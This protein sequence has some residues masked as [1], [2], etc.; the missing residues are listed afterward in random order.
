MQQGTVGDGSGPVVVDG[1]HVLAGEVMAQLRRCGVGVR[2]GAHAG[3]AAELELDAGGAAPSALVLVTAGRPP[4]AASAPWQRHGIPHL[5]VSVGIRDI[6]VG[7]LVVPGRTP[8]LVCAGAVW[9][10]ARAPG[11]A[12][13]APGA[14]TVLA[15]AIASVTVLATLR[16]DYS[17]GGIS[18]EIAHDGQAFVH[19]LWKVRADCRCA[20]VRMAG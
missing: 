18:T 11:P 14:S 8:C 7:P 17:M 3:L 15:A 1:W 19:R 16:G 13:D 12:P 4:A 2:G 10:A 9:P 6:I 5:P 20:S